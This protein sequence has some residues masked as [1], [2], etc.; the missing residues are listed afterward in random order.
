MF[1]ATLVGRLGKDPETRATS[2][3]TIIAS[4]GVAT[5][6][7]YGDNRTTEWVTCKVWGKSGSAFAEHARK[8]ATMA[9][10]GKVEIE[11]WESK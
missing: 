3:G 10:A 6:Q 5:E 2:K 7:G 1:Q 8:G 9:F 11:R 4:V